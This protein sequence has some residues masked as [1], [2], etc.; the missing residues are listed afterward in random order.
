MLTPSNAPQPFTMIN[1]V[2][3]KTSQP[4]PEHVYLLNDV[5]AFVTH[6]GGFMGFGSKRVM[7]VG[8][9]LIG[10]SRTE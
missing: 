4:R 5:N 2:A 8:L 6:R 9:P 10:P 1:D 3:Q 7:G